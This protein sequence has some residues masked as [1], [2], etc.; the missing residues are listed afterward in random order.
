[1]FVGAMLQHLIGA[2]L[3]LALPDVVFEH[4][5]FSVA[6][7]P[8][9]RSGDFE[10]GNASLHVTTMPG[11]AVVRKCAANLSAGRRPSLLP[12]MTCLPP[13]TLLRRP[14]VLR[15]AWMCWMQNSFLLPICMNWV[16]SDQISDV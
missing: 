5:G 2:K 16:A 7:G 11:E 9:G 8:T 6:D 3:S 14:K 10:I 15:I 1:M 13:Q 4:N 12:C